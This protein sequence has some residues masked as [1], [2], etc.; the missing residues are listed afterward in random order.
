[1]SGTVPKSSRIYQPPDAMLFKIPAATAVLLE[2]AADIAEFQVTTPSARVALKLSILFWQDVTGQPSAIPNYLE[3]S[4]N[5]KIT[6]GLY[7]ATADKDPV[8]NFR[9]TANI[10]GTIGPA[11]TGHTYQT[12]PVDVTGALGQQSL[13][14][15]SQTFQDGQDAVVGAVS[16]QVIANPSMGGGHHGINIS[17]RC[18]W[19]LVGSEMCDDEWTYLRGLMRIAAPDCKVYS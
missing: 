16:N 9:Q 7:L 8:G 12:I 19:E 2:A 4:L 14:G 10:V 11:N 3:A 1:M 17:L 6:T 5:G 15:Y 13:A 18:R